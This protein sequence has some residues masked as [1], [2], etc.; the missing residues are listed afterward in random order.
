MI[1]IG[2]Y[3]FESLS[4]WSSWINRK[5]YDCSFGI[6]VDMKSLLELLPIGFRDNLSKMLKTLWLDSP[7]GYYGMIEARVFALFQH[8]LHP[9]FGG[10]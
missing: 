5:F 9:L 4:E 1:T 6:V 3:S 2:K 7:A 8:I 10:D